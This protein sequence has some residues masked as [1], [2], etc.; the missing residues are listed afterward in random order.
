M[1][2]KRVSA[3]RSP[4]ENA[5]S[6]K[7][8]GIARGLWTDWLLTID[9]ASRR[10]EIEQMLLDAMDVVEQSPLEADVLRAYRAFVS[11]DQAVIHTMNVSGPGAVGIQ[12]G[13]VFSRTPPGFFADTC[14]TCKGGP[15]IGCICDA[16]QD[17]EYGPGKIEHAE[18]TPGGGVLLHETTYHVYAEREKP[19]KP[20]SGCCPGCEECCGR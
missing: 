13:D 17:E 10:L 4:E 16:G 19:E 8:A 5:H 14:E 7:R 2:K 18:R 9:E 12:V 6:A 11:A 15:P 20:P 1:T 3:L